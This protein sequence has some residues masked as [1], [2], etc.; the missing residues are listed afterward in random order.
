MNVANCGIIALKDA[1]TTVSEISSV[2]I[3]RA[4]DTADASTAT[5]KLIALQ[6]MSIATAQLESAK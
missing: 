3:I 6:Q 1:L 5:L 2:L 4:V